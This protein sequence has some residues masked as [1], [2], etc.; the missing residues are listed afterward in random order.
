MSE[1]EPSEEGRDEQP[2]TALVDE[3]MAERLEAERKRREWLE[4]ERRRRR[5]KR[6]AG[7]RARHAAKLRRNRGTE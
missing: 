7:L 4:A 5:K 1:Q 3:R 2:V 6:D